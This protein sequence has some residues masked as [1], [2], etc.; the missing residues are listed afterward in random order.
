MH[1]FEYMWL[2]FKRWACFWFRRF[3]YSV[4]CSDIRGEGTMLIT[5][6]LDC[7]KVD[8]DLIAGRKMCQLRGK[9]LWRLANPKC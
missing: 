5:K 3:L 7:F 2:L 1:V 4:K 9:V 6:A 8:A